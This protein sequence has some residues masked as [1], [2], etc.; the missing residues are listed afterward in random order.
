MLCTT[1][2]KFCKKMNHK[3][4]NCPDVICLKC[5]TVGHPHWRCDLNNNFQSPNNIKNNKHGKPSY[6]NQFKNR[7]EL[8]DSDNDSDNEYDEVKD[9]KI[10]KK[11]VKSDLNNLEILT[12]YK[13][14]RT[15]WGD[16]VCSF[17]E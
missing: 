2:C 6:A 15:P 10:E 17:N 5:K 4:D 13:H 8:L 12:D 3:I 14:N 1:G 7:F 16:I 9:N 11:Y